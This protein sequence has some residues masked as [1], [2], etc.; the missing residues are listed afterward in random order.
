PTQT[1]QVVPVS[2]RLPFGRA[3]TVLVSHETLLTFFIGYL[4]A[5]VRAILQPICHPVPPPLIYVEFFNFSNLHYY[6]VDNIHIAAP[7]P[8][9]EMFLVQRRFQSNGRPLGDIIPLDNVR[10]VVQLI[11]KFGVKAPKEMTCDNCLDVGREFYLN[12]FADKET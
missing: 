12:S 10:Q 8:K 6:M 1:V 3:N 5:Q 11:P 2:E 4:V 9:I 7:A